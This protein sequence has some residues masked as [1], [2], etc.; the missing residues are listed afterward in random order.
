MGML[1][2][3]LKNGAIFAD[4]LSSFDAMVKDWAGVISSAPVLVASP[5]GPTLSFDGIDDK[6]A[7]SNLELVA[8]CKSVALWVYL[9]STTEQIIDL[10]GGTHYIHALSGTVT[11]T[12]F[13]SPTIYVDGA[14][15]S[16][17]TA[18]A[19][20]HVVVTTGTAFNPSNIQLATDNTNFGKVYLADCSVWDRALAAAEVTDLYNHQTFDHKQNQVSHWQMDD[21]VLVQDV[22]W[23]GNGLDLTVNGSPL[24]A[25]GIAG[26]QALSLDGAAD[27]LSRAPIDLSGGG[28]IALWFKANSV[29]ATQ[30]IFTQTSSSSNREGIFIATSGSVEGAFYDGTIRL[31]GRETIVVDRWYHAVLTRIGTTANFYLNGVLA[32][33]SGG[34]VGSGGS[35]LAF[36][37]NAVGTPWWFNG[38]VDEAHMFDIDLT[39]LQVRDLF[40]STRAGRT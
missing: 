28:S 16:A 3:H 13:T 23:K 7:I 5:F 4:S 34:A 15:S 25:N 6:I 35:A 37:R 17:I 40:E 32:T 38:L 19:W 12:G 10:D 20:H 29:A 22:G 2:R 26:R 31:G 14:V 27:Y 21:T 33:L 24:R 30:G 18:S 11:A 39:E 36:G 1:R 8:Q 9:D